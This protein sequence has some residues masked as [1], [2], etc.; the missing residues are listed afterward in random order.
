MKQ[1]LNIFDDMPPFSS[2]EMND[3]ILPLSSSINDDVFDAD[4]FESIVEKPTAD[5][6][7][8]EMEFEPRIVQ[9]TNF[10][11][12][13]NFDAETLANLK[14][15]TQSD[16]EMESE[17][18]I[19]YEVKYACEASLFTRNALQA[20]IQRETSAKL[21]PEDPQDFSSDNKI[22]LMSA[23]EEHEIFT[24]LKKLLS[25]THSNGVD[26]PAWVRR[27]Y[28]K[29]CVRNIQRSAG[30][31]VFNLDNYLDSQSFSGTRATE[32]VIL[33]RFHH[34]LVESDAGGN[35]MQHARLA[36]SVQSDFFASPYTG[37]V[38]HPFIFRN[39]YCVP[40]W[41]KLMCELQYEVNGELASRA[42][43]DYSY[44]RPQHIAAVNA[45]LQRMFWPGIDSENASRQSQSGKITLFSSYFQCPNV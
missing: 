30:Q 26:E 15:A 34:L 40:P 19:P 11:E 23:Y 28:R 43:V 41:V 32:N 2:D 14:Q 45:L 4:F 38:L 17:D 7:V 37:R 27:Y 10:Q 9:V 42:S 13:S 6:P 31:K 8:D 35:L 16:D 18:E 1:E 21:E 29:L 25:S 22:E 20:D 33:D 44:V 5:E 12:D 24:R 36:G 39:D 3:V